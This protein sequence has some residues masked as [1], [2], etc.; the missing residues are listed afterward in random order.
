MQFQKTGGPRIEDCVKDQA[1]VAPVKVSSAQG[2]T[3][4]R[5][6]RIP[7]LEEPEDLLLSVLVSHV[8]VRLAQKI[9]RTGTVYDLKV[10]GGDR[11]LQVAKYKGLSR[12]GSIIEGGV[13]RMSH[14]F[15][16]GRS[17]G[18]GV[19]LAQ[20]RLVSSGQGDSSGTG[21]D[22]HAR[23]GKACN[24]GRIQTRISSLAFPFLSS[25]RL[26]LMAS[27]EGSMMRF[28]Q[29]YT[30]LSFLSSLAQ[31]PTN[32]QQ[33]RNTVAPSSHSTAGS[34]RLQQRIPAVSSGVSWMCLLRP[35]A[36]ALPGVTFPSPAAVSSAMNGSSNLRASSSR[37]QRGAKVLRPYA[38]AAIVPLF[39]PCSPGEL[40]AA[41]GAADN[42]GGPPFQSDERNERFD[43]GRRRLRTS[44]VRTRGGRRR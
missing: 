36:S 20:E 22:N 6:G 37:E 34:A 30:S 27:S 26:A 4:G 28:H 42:D 11:L 33:W 17:G 25:G 44:S 10:R 19:S 35:A 15:N 40:V 16:S 7:S 31:A 8:V 43:G 38:A 23:R 29:D 3:G 21:A 1:K 2:P 13:R 12:S 32:R 9:G 14:L 39:P 41:V 18:V 5:E 24:K